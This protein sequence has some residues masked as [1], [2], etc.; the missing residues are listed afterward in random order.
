MVG[1]K[2]RGAVHLRDPLASL[3]LLFG[4]RTKEDIA[5]SECVEKLKALL[6][7]S[8]KQGEFIE[9][10]KKVWKKFRAIKGKVRRGRPSQWNRVWAEIA[11]WYLSKKRDSLFSRASD[12]QL[13]KHVHSIL[14]EL[15][16]D[17]IRKYVKHWRLLGTPTPSHP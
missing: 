5:L 15:D 11:G 3:K 4:T 10:A 7:D 2:A 6:Q 14:H 17:T 8:Q 12:Y 9:E 13:I 16:E 1:P